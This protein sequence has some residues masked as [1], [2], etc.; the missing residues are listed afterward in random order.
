MSMASLGYFAFILAWSWLAN[1]QLQ[2]R[3]LTSYCS[4]GVVQVIHFVRSVLY[5]LFA[6]FVFA[7][8]LPSRNLSTK[9]WTSA[10]WLLGNEQ[11]AE[12]TAWLKPIR[13]GTPSAL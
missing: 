13:S 9:A 4:G 1:F 10:V 12:A 2:D 7:L 5:E 3:V 6:M 8:V 11:C